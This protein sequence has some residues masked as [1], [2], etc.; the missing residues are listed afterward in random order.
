MMTATIPDEAVASCRNLA[1]WLLRTCAEYDDRVRAAFVYRCY[2]RALVFAQEPARTRRWR[3]FI[4]A[5][6]AYLSTLQD[7]NSHAIAHLR[8]IVQ[9]NADLLEPDYGLSE[10]DGIVSGSIAAPVAFAV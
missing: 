8:S 7:A 2:V 5:L 3:R 9:E 6:H 10:G 1:V 4:R